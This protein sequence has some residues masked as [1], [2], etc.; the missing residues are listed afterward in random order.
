M[1]CTPCCKELE[2]NGLI[3]C[4]FC[5]IQGNWEHEDIPLGSGVRVL[6]IDGAGFQGLSG[7][8]FLQKI[9]QQ[10]GIQ[11]HH[12][13]DLIVGTDSGALSALGY[14]AL[15]KTGDQMVQLFKKAKVYLSEDRHSTSLELLDQVSS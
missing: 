2:I 13:F 11:I 7:A 9:E 10:L 5:S 3:E 14:G 1:L 15:Y 12:L 6:I 8:L 4:P